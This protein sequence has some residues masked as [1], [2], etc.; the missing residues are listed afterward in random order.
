MHLLMM[1][2]QMAEKHIRCLLV[3]NEEVGARTGQQSIE[4]T[5]IIITWYF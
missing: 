2:P 3:T 4:N 5:L 1:M